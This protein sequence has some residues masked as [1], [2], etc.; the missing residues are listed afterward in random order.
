MDSLNALSSFSFFLSAKDLCDE[1]Q[2]K[3]REDASYIKDLQAMTQ[4]TIG[5]QIKAKALSKKHKRIG[6]LEKNNIEQAEAA[7]YAPP[8]SGLRKDAFNG[9]W[10]ITFRGV[11]QTL[12]SCSRSWKR[13]GGEGE[14]KSLLMTLQTAWTSY[15]TMT[16]LPCPHEGIVV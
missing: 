10:Q 14:H 9:R 4:K 1:S 5:A 7:L 2:A 12:P 16:G 8:E 15:T 11:L 13:L 3:K 6:E